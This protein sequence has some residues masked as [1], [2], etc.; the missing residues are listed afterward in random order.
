MP[1]KKQSIGLGSWIF[2]ILGILLLI[3]LIMFFILIMTGKINLSSKE[4]VTNTTIIERLENSV[5]SDTCS[6]TCDKSFIEIGEKVTCTLLDGKYNNFNLYAKYE[7][8]D[9]YLVDTYTTD[10]NGIKVAEWTPAVT[11]NY[12]FRVLCLNGNS[13]SINLEV[14]DTPPVEDD[15]PPEDDSWNDNENYVP[16]ACADIPPTFESGDLGQYCE[17]GA[18]EDQFNCDNYWNYADKQH[19]CACSGTYFCGQYCFSYYFT[20]SCDCP[21]GSSI[22]NPDR[23]HFMCVPDGYIC[24]DGVP[25]EVVGVW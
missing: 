10:G 25:V 21:P 7:A 8:M 1:K 24:E 13:D 12:Q 20:T 6:L 2:G 11:G 9:W 4:T 17:S 22:V 15:P 16:V 14:G 23:S 5:P 18:C 19:E 3:A